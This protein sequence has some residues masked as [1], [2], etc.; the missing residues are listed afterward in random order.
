MHL[1]LSL[2]PALREPLLGRVP[3][4][5]TRS[6]F[7][8][9]V[10]G[11]RRIL[12]I[13]APYVDPTITGLLNGVTVPVRIVTTATAGRPSR[14][15]PVLERLSGSRSLD[16]RYLRESADRALMYQAQ[17][18]LLLADGERAYVGSANLTDTSM[19]YN[20]ELGLYVTEAT[21]VS[22]I[23]RFFDVLFDRVAVAAKDLRGGRDEE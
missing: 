21:T 8:E 16:V 3:A 18:K 2:P 20:L 17:A 1:V 5:E 10:R 23:D 11:A 13:V 22:A 15:N 19:H 6:A 12:K 9:L 14:P 7:E 4:V